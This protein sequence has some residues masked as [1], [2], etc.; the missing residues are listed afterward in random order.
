VVLRRHLR[1]LLAIG[2]YAPA[3]GATSGPPRRFVGLIV[4]FC[5]HTATSMKKSVPATP[6]LPGVVRAVGLG[7]AALRLEHNCAI[8]PWVVLAEVMANAWTIGFR[9]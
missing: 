5:G 6:L 1:R 4:L 9:H 3:L 7:L 8:L 2:G